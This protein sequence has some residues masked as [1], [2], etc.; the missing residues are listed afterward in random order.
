VN[1][2][3]T[4]TQK[5]SFR[6]E[7]TWFLADPHFGHDSIRRACNR[8]FKT[9]EEMDETLRQNLKVVQD[10]E[11]LVVVGDLTWNN[12]SDDDVRRLPGKHKILVRGNHDKQ[13]IT[14]SRKWS[15]VC[16]YLEAT[17]LLSDNTKRMAVISHYPMVSWAGARRSIHL[18]GHTHGAI[19][20]IATEF[21]GRVD[22][23]VD[24][25][26]YRPIRIYEAMAWLDA[27]RPNGYAVPGDY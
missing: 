21:G 8:P 19:A 3:D 9:V 15:R 11:T 7:K 5:I 17:M 1:T 16:D 24:V 6:A 18:H 14:K 22:V 4:T 10:D 20:P 25:W 13:V 2:I 27:L 26:D 12:K 23:G